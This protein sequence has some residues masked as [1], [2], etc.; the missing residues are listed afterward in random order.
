LALKVKAKT[1][2]GRVSETQSE[3]QFWDDAERAAIA[4]LGQRP[5]DANLHLFR[6]AVSLPTTRD[7]SPGAK[8]SLDW[9]Q[10]RQ[11]HL[12]L[13]HTAMMMIPALIYDN[14]FDHADAVLDS[15][16]RWKSQ[17]SDKWVI[18]RLRGNVAAERAAQD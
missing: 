9:L 4:A 11:T 17:R 16:E 1:A 15:A 14:R 10:T 13:P 18:E 7:L 12:R 8:A 3:L 6:V 2:Y 5:D